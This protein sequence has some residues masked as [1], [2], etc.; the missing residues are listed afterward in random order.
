MFRFIVRKGDPRIRA[1]GIFELDTPT[2]LEP[3]P[4]ASKKLQ[5]RN[6]QEYKNPLSKIRCGITNRD[7]RSVID[8]AASARTAEILLLALST[9]T[10][11]DFQRRPPDP[12]EAE[13]SITISSHWPIMLLVPTTTTGVAATTGLFSV[14]VDSAVAFHKKHSADSS[15]HE[16]RTF[17]ANKMTSPPG[18]R[19]DFDGNVTDNSVEL[20][21]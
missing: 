4:H 18:M 2:T 10:S 17:S 11:I 9:V 20:F 7:E 13:M 5:R 14:T 6:F 12:E 19:V 1:A 21:H 15:E 3:S 16:A 8:R